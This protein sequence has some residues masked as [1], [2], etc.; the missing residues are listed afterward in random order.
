[1]SKTTDELNRLYDL[2][3]D[4]LE[5]K[6]TDCQLA[7]ISDGYYV[8]SDLPVTKEIA[9][10]TTRIHALED[11]LEAQEQAAANYDCTPCPPQP[12]INLDDVEE[13]EF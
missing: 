13:I 3:A 8:E 4:L 7:I 2:R 12:V 5:K 1:M 9:A 11:E 6:R 10:V